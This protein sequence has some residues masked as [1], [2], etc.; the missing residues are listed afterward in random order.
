MFKQAKANVTILYQCEECKRD[1]MYV[2]AFIEL[3]DL[4]DFKREVVQ[5]MR[6]EGY[7]VEK[8]GKWFC[9]DCS[10]GL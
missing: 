1:I 2:G 5:T 10:V 3:D 4:S 7:K 9:R 6:A 8:E